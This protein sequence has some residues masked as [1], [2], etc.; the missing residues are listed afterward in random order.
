MIMCVLAR[1]TSRQG[2]SVAPVWPKAEQADRVHRFLAASGLI[3]T[4]LPREDVPEAAG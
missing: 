4:M 2:M 1:C 3:E